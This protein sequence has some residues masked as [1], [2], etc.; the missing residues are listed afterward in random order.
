MHTEADSNIHE[1]ASNKHQHNK[2]SHEVNFKIHLQQNNN[3]AI[4]S[5]S[6][7]VTHRSFIIIIIIHNIRSNAVTSA[8]ES[9]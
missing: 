6:T 8:D 4:K 2:M 5:N 7:T 9:H 3:A 1:T